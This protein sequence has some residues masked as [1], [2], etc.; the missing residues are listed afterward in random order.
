MTVSVVDSELK[1]RHRAMWASGDYPF[2]ADHSST[3]S[4]QMSSIRRRRAVEATR[5]R[6]SF[7]R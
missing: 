3:P 6:P 2:I 7:R 5:R 1:A 4:D